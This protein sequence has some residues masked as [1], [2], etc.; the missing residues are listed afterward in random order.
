ME[1]LIHCAQATTSRSSDVLK[2]VDGTRLRK[3]CKQG[4]IEIKAMGGDL[5]QRCHTRC[6]RWVGAEVCQFS[7]HCDRVRAGPFCNGGAAS[8]DRQIDPVHQTG[9]GEKQV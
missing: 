9:H 6:L 1:R 4:L 7:Y 5:P 2:D 8:P 3:G